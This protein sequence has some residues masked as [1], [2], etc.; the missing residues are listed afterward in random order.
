MT[1]RIEPFLSNMTDFFFSTWLIEIEP[2]FS[3]WLKE[4]EPICS[5]TWRIFYFFKIYDSNKGIL[6]WKTWLKELNPLRV[7]LTELIFFFWKMTH[8][9]ETFWWTFF[10]YD[11][12][13]WTFTMTQRFQFLKKVDAENWTIFLNMTQRS[14][15]FF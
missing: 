14:G 5:V 7:W 6:F 15:P 12:K 11:S 4:I 3:T 1:R 10:Q 9:I 2:F 13:N 8:R